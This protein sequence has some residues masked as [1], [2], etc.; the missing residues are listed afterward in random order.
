MVHNRG[1]ADREFDLPRFKAGVLDHLGD[2]VDLVLD[3]FRERFRSLSHRLHAKQRQLRGHV[4]FLDDRAAVGSDFAN[5]V[6]RYSGAPVDANVRDHV[7]AG[8]EIGQRRQ[9]GQ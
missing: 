8:N 9:L 1:S 3:H 6:V 7:E 4:A 2:G 5:D